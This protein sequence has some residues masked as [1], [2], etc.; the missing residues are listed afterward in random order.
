MS[1]VKSQAPPASSP[2]IHRRGYSQSLMSSR[3][4][5]PQPRNIAEFF[6]SLAAIEIEPSQTIDLSAGLRVAG[7]A[8]GHRRFDLRSIATKG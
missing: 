3:S 6:Q 5:Q 7:I 4:V 8:Q 2:P 1:V